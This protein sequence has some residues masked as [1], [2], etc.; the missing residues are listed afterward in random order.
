MVLRIRLFRI[1]FSNL[2]YERER[3]SGTQGS[4]RGNSQSLQRNFVFEDFD[5]FLTEAML[6]VIRNSVSDPSHSSLQS[7]SQAGDDVA[8]FIEGL[9]RIQLILD[10]GADVP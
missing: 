6:S 2:T 1:C 3:S 5:C 9:L 7:R 8:Q 4:K 10:L